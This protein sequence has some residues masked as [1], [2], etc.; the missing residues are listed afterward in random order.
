[1]QTRR[2]LLLLGTLAAV[3]V[4]GAIL[5]WPSSTSTTATGAD[6]ITSPDTGGDGSSSAL[7]EERN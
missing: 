5:L 6:S 7:L 4:A 3:L 1:M 2:Y